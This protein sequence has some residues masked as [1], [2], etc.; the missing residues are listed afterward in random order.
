LYMEEIEGAGEEIDQAVRRLASGD[1]G[2]A[3]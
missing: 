1:A 3:N 2:Q